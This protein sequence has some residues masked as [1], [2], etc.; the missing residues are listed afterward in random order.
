MVK[1]D[2]TDRSLLRA[3]QENAGLSTSAL[4]EQLGISQTS[5]WRKLRALEDSGVLLSPTR[6]IDAARVGLTV[7]VIC[8]LRLRDHLPATRQEFLHFVEGR[9]E[10]LE[11]FAMSGEWDFLLRII[12][13]S[14]EGYQ[15]FLMRR[16]LVQ[17]AVATASSHFVLSVDKFT[18]TV[19]V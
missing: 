17:P 4:A 14:V 13:D 2:A 18:T 7:N 16:L 9:S 11:C 19:P 5:C 15:A 8:N 3:L 12:A 6:S 1:L 10:I